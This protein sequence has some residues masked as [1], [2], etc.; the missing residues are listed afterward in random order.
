MRIENGELDNLV[1]DKSGGAINGSRIQPFELSVGLGSGDKEA[2]RVVQGI[3][4]IESQIAA[5]HDVKSAG[6]S[7]EYIENIHVVEPAVG[8]VDKA[9]DAAA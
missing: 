1:T 9:W 2:T 3:K 8:D 6:F 4:P 7:D 5:V